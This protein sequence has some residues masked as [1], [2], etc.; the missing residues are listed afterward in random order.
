MTT[1][2][3]SETEWLSVGLIQTTLD[4]GNAWKKGPPMS[5]A[6]EQQ[7]QREI[8]RALA[9][10]KNDG[11]AADIILIPEL[12]APRGMQD[13][14]KQ[15]ARQLK[16]IIISGLDYR[17]RGIVKRGRVKKKLVSNEACLFIPR[18]WRSHKRQT[19]V[20][21]YTIGKTYAAKEE[22]K[23]LGD[24]GCE[25]VPDPN[26]YIF[27]GA[28]IG[29]FAVLICFDLMDLTRASLYRSRI[30]H[31]FVLAYNRDQTSFGHLAEAISRTVFCNVVICNTG[32]HG[33]SVAVAPYKDTWLR[34]VYRHDGQKLFTSQIIKLPVASLVQHKQGMKLLGPELKALPPGFKKPAKLNVHGLKT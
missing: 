14:L 32:Y 12:A 4:N 7:A 18:R 26:M 6:E 33:G 9:G 1:S 2:R 3:N 19:Q 15:H 30:D 31:L 13:E 27:D 8:R 22:E 34:T 24:V 23:L 28:E 5:D 29:K 16:T 21:K 10:F 20:T 25:F 11:A 17:I